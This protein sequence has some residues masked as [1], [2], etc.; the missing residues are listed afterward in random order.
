MTWD[1]CRAQVKNQ[2]K[3]SYKKSVRE[4]ANPRPRR[5]QP[6]FRRNLGD[7]R[8]FLR[9]IQNFSKKFSSFVTT[10]RP[11]SRLSISKGRSPIR[12]IFGKKADG[13]TA[14]RRAGEDQTRAAGH[15]PATP[16]T[17]ATERAT[18]KGLWTHSPLRQGRK[19]TRRAPACRSSRSR[20][21]TIAFA[22]A[23]RHL[24]K[25]SRTSKKK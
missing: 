12:T 17:P 2:A 22:A 18:P 4:V 14:E 21:R 8:R 3:E 25:L 15:G 20:E 11:N 5:P 24:K 10:F 1:N 6:K 23:G 9:K 13:S 7:Q 16:P 19:H